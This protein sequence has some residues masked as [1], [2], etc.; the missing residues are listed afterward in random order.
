MNTYTNT[1]AQQI[2]TYLQL[3]KSMIFHNQYHSWHTK[4][5]HLQHDLCINTKLLKGSKI[6]K[7]KLGKQ[8]ENQLGTS[9]YIRDSKNHIK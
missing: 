4:K 3:Q 9:T 5:F 1:H 7:L 2:N 6:K 8:H